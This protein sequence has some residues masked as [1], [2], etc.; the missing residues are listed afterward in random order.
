[1]DVDAVTDYRITIRSTEDLRRFTG[2]FSPARVLFLPDPVEDT[3]FSQTEYLK[4]APCFAWNPCP[5]LRVRVVMCLDQEMQP[6]VHYNPYDSGGLEFFQTNLRSVILD[7]SLFY[8]GHQ[9][10]ITEYWDFLDSWNYR[11]GLLKASRVN[12]QNFMYGAQ[13][14]GPDRVREV[15]TDYLDDHNAFLLRIANTS[16]EDLTE[17]L[18]RR[19]TLLD[20]L[21]VS[22]HPR[23]IDYLKE[24]GIATPRS[25][26]NRLQ[27]RIHALER[28]R[29]GS[30][31]SIW[32][33]LDEA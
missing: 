6:Y 4:G 5:D 26:F 13:A 24:L 10:T 28:G 29:V 7:L 16:P 33:H 11:P 12:F 20:D 31:L 2:P 19:S 23:N 30:G 1:M 8:L 14:R 9:G 3:E 25:T 22:T 32:E 18:E 17:I 15:V 27:D 21:F